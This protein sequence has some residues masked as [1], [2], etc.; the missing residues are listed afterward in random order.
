MSSAL[1]K[2]TRETIGQWLWLMLPAT[3]GVV[4]V[5][6]GEA[7]CS[8]VV[9]M[10][11]EKLAGGLLLLVLTS[12]CYLLVRVYELRSKKS[13]YERLVPVPGK[14][15]SRDPVTGEIACPRCTS[16]EQ[17]LFMRDHGEHTYFCNGCYRGILK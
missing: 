16:E 7:I 12:W 17:I 11:G 5:R 9:A 8:S 2:Q 14:G 15:Y 4:G 13:V 10:F 6:F 1:V 3:G